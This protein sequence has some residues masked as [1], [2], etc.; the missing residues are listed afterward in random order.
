MRFTTHP[1]ENPFVL[2]AQ[3]Q[4]ILDWQ[5]LH[6]VSM[7]A[8]LYEVEYPVRYACYT[9]LYH[10]MRLWYKGWTLLDFGICVMLTSDRNVEISIICLVGWMLEFN[11]G[12]FKFDLSCPCQM[13]F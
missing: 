10:G 1:L 6:S 3:V 5:S 7:F 2:I 8:L 12:E 4:V 9:F 11:E 13:M